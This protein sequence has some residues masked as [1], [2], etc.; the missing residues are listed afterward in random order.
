MATLAACFSEPVAAAAQGM[1]HGATA[2]VAWKP[3]K[4]G[5]G[6]NRGNRRTD[7]SRF[8]S[9]LAFPACSLPVADAGLPH[10]VACYIPSLWF[11]SSW[12]LALLL[13][14]PL[15][16]FIPCALFPAGVFLYLQFQCVVFVVASAVPCFDFLVMLSPLT[17]ALLCLHYLLMLSF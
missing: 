4:R 10:Y 15:L 17:G 5:G 7:V 2:C 11:L 9:V 16:P 8:P 13:F 14:L 1:P 6:G 3:K 12:C